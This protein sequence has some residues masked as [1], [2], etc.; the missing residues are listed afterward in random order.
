MA[1][2]DWY[3]WTSYGG[4][5]VECDALYM[6]DPGSGTIWRCDPVGVGVLLCLWV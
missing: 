1:P 6:F 3:V 2:I 4:Q 5:G